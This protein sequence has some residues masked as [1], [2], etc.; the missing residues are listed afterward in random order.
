MNEQQGD[1]LP[2]ETMVGLKKLN[3]SMYHLKQG[4]GGK[5]TKWRDVPL[6]YHRKLIGQ[7]FE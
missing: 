5:N 6:S 2:V 4:G 3:V 7:K 1:V